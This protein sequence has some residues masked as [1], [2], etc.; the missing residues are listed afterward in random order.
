MV[1]FGDHPGQKPLIYKLIHKKAA[2]FSGKRDSFSILT[3]F[4]GA[5]NQAKI[6]SHSKPKNHDYM[7]G[8]LAFKIPFKELIHKVLPMVSERPLSAPIRRR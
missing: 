7:N 5:F 2:F 6:I 4:Q 1:T 3:N 8:T